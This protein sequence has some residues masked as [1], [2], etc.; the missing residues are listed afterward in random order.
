MKITI[1]GSL[2]HIG[3]PL[4]EELVQKGHTVT[5]VSSNPA[6][7]KDID[8]LGARAAI[9][10]MEDVPFLT[11]SFAAADAVYC[12]LPPGN[13]FDHDL[14]LLS[15]W[16]GIARNYVQAIRQSGVKRVVYLSSVGADIDKGHGILAYHHDAENI[17]RTL[18]DEVAVTFMR[19]V[20]FYYNLYG[21]VNGIKTQGVIA[22]NYGAGDKVPWVSPIDIAAAIAEEI[23]SPF[24]GR[25]IRYVASEEITCN[26]I[27]GI[28]GEAI[29]KPGL[30]WILVTGEQL[31]SGLIA[32]GMNPQFAAG[33]VEMNATI[34]S[35]VLFEDYYRNRPVLGKT[36]VKDFA[37]EFAA[38]YNQK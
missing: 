37:K 18:P 7:Q 35:G 5:V 6:K 12:M 23:T 16:S 14:D 30:K 24:T 36:K 10:A 8:A 28:L 38:V 31:Q 22:A 21:F 11:S 25:K 2:G 26:E 29:G 15:S 19:P 20:G 13:Y 17:M 27:A 34:H 3:K 33:L 9:G 32:A 1:T 4:A